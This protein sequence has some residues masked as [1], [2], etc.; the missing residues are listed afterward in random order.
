MPS[1]GPSA[2]QSLWFHHLAYAYTKSS[3]SKSAAFNW[4][5]NYRL[6][7]TT[8][9]PT[10]SRI[11]ACQQSTSSSLLCVSRFTVIFLI[12]TDDLAVT[13]AA[14]GDSSFRIHCICNLLY[15]LFTELKCWSEL[16]HFPLGMERM[17]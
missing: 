9:P 11:H 2:K 14:W 4:R 13:W 6:S 8:S 10:R 3:S 17:K 7:E 12:S 1:D 5:V 15:I 16:V